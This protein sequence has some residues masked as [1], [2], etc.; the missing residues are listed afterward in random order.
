MPTGIQFIGR[1]FG[2]QTILNASYA[3]EKEIGRVILDI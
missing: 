3:L 1:H 2:E